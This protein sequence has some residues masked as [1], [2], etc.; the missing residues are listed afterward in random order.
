MV[1]VALLL[2]CG[3]EQGWPQSGDE[4]NSISAESLVENNTN[5]FV[6]ITATVNQNI[7]HR[8]GCPEPK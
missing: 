5:Y 4:S 7:A 2:S 1:G 3:L 6:Y 8:N